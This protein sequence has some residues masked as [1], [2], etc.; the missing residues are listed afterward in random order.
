MVGL[1]ALLIDM[2]KA[3]IVLASGP[4]PVSMRSFSQIYFMKELNFGQDLEMLLIIDVLITVQQSN[5]P[6]WHK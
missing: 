2:L 3:S 4:V 1:S 5:W 6:M